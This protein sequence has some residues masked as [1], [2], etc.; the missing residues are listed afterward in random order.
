MFCYLYFRHPSSFRNYL[1]SEDSERYPVAPISLAFVSPPQTLLHYATWCYMM[2]HG[3][4]RVIIKHLLIS[5]IYI[6]IQYKCVSY[7]FESNLHFAPIHVELCF[8]AQDSP[9]GRLV[10]DKEEEEP[11]Q[12]AA[13]FNNSSNRP[14]LRTAC[15]A[16]FFAPNITIYT[17]DLYLCLPLPMVISDVHSTFLSKNIYIS[18][19]PCFQLL[20]CSWIDSISRCF[21]GFFSTFFVSMIDRW[22]F[23]PPMAWCSSWPRRA[24][25]RHK[26]SWANG[27]GPRPANQ[28]RNHFGNDF[29]LMFFLRLIFIIHLY[30]YYRNL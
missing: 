20:P 30:S 26:W 28:T 5:D 27:A 14:Q 6:Y 2:L 9:L 21:M 3:I 1:F 18:S 22:R 13:R 11:A 15:A 23:R 12:A 19:F 17:S 4:V 8:M 16:K 7:V 29:F 24:S 10:R 25:Q